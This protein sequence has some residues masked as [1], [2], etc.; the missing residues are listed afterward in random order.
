[1]CF[2][3]VMMKKGGFL[4]RT[5][6]GSVEFF[7]SCVD[8]ASGVDICDPNACCQTVHILSRGEIDCLCGI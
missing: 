1:M 5:V 6:E 4:P 3:S 7:D 8:E 2:D